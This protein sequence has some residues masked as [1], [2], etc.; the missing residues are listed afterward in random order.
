MWMRDAA[1][2]ARNRRVY[3]IDIPGEPG[4]SAE[5]CL[6]WQG[7]GAAAWLGEVVAGLGLVD[8]DL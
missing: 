5:T 3:A 4:L 1:V 2:L 8:V 7:A 6:D